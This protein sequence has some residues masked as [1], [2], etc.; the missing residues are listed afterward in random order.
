MAVC[1]VWN[2]GRNAN[3]PGSSTCTLRAI[4][5]GKEEL[6]TSGA[7]V[8]TVVS[9]FHLNTRRCVFIQKCSRLFLLT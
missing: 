4:L 7:S 8:G 2:S 1:K 6:M 9:A 3:K 5:E